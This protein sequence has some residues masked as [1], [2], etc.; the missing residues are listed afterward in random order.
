MVNLKIL[1]FTDEDGVSN[2]QMDILKEI[3]RKYKYME[4]LK[5]NKNEEELVKKYDVKEFPTVIID[6]GNG[7]KR[8]SGLTQSLFLERAINELITMNI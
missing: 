1:F 7:I 2:L 6:S 3:K 8:F 4:L 5:I